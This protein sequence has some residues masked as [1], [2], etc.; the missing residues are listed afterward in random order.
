MPSPLDLHPGVFSSRGLYSPS[1]EGSLRRI[2]RTL[3]FASLILSAICA[4]C[5]AVGG[6]DPPLAPPSVTVT[7]NSAQPFTG[8]GVQFSALV[9]GAP[10]SAVMWEVNNVPNGN[11]SVGTIN[12]SGYYTAP[13]TLPNPNPVTVAAVL[14]ADSSVSGSALVTV[15][16]PS[17]IQSLALSPALASVTT[18]QALQLQVVTPGITVSDVNWA[19]DGVANGSAANGTIS[20]SGNFA[21]YSPPPT[22]GPHLVTAQLIANPGA[23][24]SA[25]V[26]VTDFP[27]TLTWRND[28][29]RSGVNSQELALAP[30][31]V[32][33][34]TFGKLFSC[35]IDGDAYAQPLYVPNLAIPGMGTHNVVFVATEKDSVFAFDAD[36]NPCQ[37]LWQASLIPAGSEVISTPN[38]DIASTDI[39]PYV[40]ITGTPVISLNT[41]ALYVVSKTV[42]P[43]NSQNLNSVYG[44]RLYAL[45]L[46]TGENKIQTQGIQFATPEP[47]PVFSSLLE[48]QRA[49]L[50]LEDP[51]IYVAFA[52]H[53]GQGDYHGWLFAYDS[54]T[55]EQT[56]VFNVTANSIQGGIWQ[57]G[58]G[59]SVD[60]S[61]LNHFLYVATGEGPPNVGTNYSDSIV[62]MT[63]IGGLSVADFFTPCDQGQ[64]PAMNADAS[65]QSMSSA[66]ILFQDPV[67][68]TNL[69][70]GGS[71]E[72][73]LYIVNR[74]SMG[75]F[76][77]KCPDS[78]PRVQAI[79]VGGAIFSTPLYWNGSVYVAPANGNLQQ[80][81]I[82]AGVLASTSSA[83]QSPETLGPQ[84]ATP[85][86]SSNNTSNAVLWLIDSSGALAATNTP[87]ILRAYD[88]NNLSNEIYNSAMVPKR[89]TAGLAVKFTVPT[90]ANGKVYVGTQGELDVYGLLP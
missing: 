40:G 37:Q 45:D 55:L 52:S 3:L 60:P 70:I 90:V 71:K 74:E 13:G 57:S 22:A 75:G 84:G 7:P 39:V 35:T 89:D 16:S 66:P 80:F 54:T 5:G 31:T 77:S 20:T 69:L 63:T 8:G 1:R 67:S 21:I 58:G 50:L 26:E 68:Q 27:G 6:S 28:N 47:G 72:G 14:Q 56:A 87:A 25:Q 23:L 53:G 30:S 29:L 2:S 15:E 12:S 82:S 61:D 36:A 78:A 4:S 42:A 62:R 10:S 86:I 24:G 19:V 44:Q 59:P 88:P 32:S 51:I 76:V 46:A 11:S 83:A 64:G 38:A 81:P 34:S 17:S 73:F 49:A 43:G 18:S 33:S 79:P 85:V 9:Q 48:N 41:S 65:L